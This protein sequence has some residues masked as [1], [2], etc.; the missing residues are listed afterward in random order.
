MRKANNFHKMALMKMSYFCTHFVFLCCYNLFITIFTVVITHTG[1]FILYIAPSH[2]KTNK[3]TCVPRESQISLGFCPV[4]SASSLY[5]G[6]Q[7]FIY[8]D[9]E[10]WSDWE[11]AQAELSLRWAACNIVDFVMWR[12]IFVL[13]SPKPQTFH[14]TSD[15]F[16]IIKYTLEKGNPLDF[17]VR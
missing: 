13:I 8:A 17:K 6:P 4:W 5:E 16:S 3:M 2:D 10:D 9:S 7:T 11:D 15:N 1:S 12:L 14:C